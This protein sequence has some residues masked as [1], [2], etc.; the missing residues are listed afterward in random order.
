MKKVSIFLAAAVVTLSSFTAIQDWKADKGH[1]NL[2]FS[3]T[4]LGINDI[5]GNFK[6]FEA[7][8]KSSK[9]DFSDAQVELTGDISSINTNIEMRDKHL[10]GADFFDAAKYPTFN[11]KSTGIKPAGKNTYKVNGNLTLHGVT[12]PVTLTL[13][14]RGVTTNPM[15]KAPTAGFKVTGTIKRSDFNLGAGFPAPM[16]SDEVAIKAD[17]EFTS[18]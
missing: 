1:S 2:G 15:S 5:Q 13:V 14:N 9:A 16:L 10:Q 8:V 17:G 4:H 12:K 18:K 7:T 11:F 6:N 3:I